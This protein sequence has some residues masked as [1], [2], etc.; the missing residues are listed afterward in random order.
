MTKLPVLSGKELIQILERHGFEVVRTK[1]SHISLRKSNE[2][3]VWKT[4]VPLHDTLA[5][6]TLMD[7]LRQTG[8]SK[9]DL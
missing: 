7:I 9:D 2:D 3:G 6:G 5:R 8:L 1:G 4:V